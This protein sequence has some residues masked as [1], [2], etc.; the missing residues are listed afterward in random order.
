MRKHLAW[1]VALTFALPSFAAAQTVVGA[2]I[3]LGVASLSIDDDDEDLDSRK[4]IN[5][6]VFVGI[7]LTETF[8]IQ[9]G[10]SYMQKGATDSQD[11]FEMAIELDYITLPLLGVFRVPSEG[12]ASLHLFAGPTFAFEI[13]C[14]VSMEGGGEDT[15]SDC[16]DPGTEV[17]TK[18]FDF[19][20]AVGAAVSYAVSDAASLFLSGFYNLGLTNVNDDDSGVDSA[21]NRIFGVNVGLVF[22]VGG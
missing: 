4:G 22:P 10:L 13:S 7:P 9:P 11:G 21:K 15:S 20:A 16:E 3:G 5:F 14:E 6:G 18:S 19:G 8:S 12:P 1:V 17:N 2:S